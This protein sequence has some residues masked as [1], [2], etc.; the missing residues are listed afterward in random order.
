[1]SESVPNAETLR[2]LYIDEQQSL[3][4]VGRLY[5]VHPNQVRRWLLRALIP[6]RSVSEG[7]ILSGKYGV[8]SEAHREALRGGAVKARAKITSESRKK[9]SAT[10]IQRQIEPWN[11][12]IPMSDAQREKLAKTWNDPEHRRRQAE[13]QRGEKG[14]N[15]QGGKRSELDRRL[16]S[17]EWRQTRA[18]I[19]ERDNWLCQECGCKCL[20]SRD[21]K[22]HPKRK[23][24]CHHIVSRRN[25]GSDEMSNLTTLCMSCHHKLERASAQ[26][27][28]G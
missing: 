26:T 5:G 20:N 6:T 11:K 10:R 19:Y 4:G 23:I 18:K 24:Q 16:D 15:W 13:R 8:Q 27:V 2:R 14:H 21:S 25:G 22:A 1:M 12:G 3:A 9:Q 28:Q 17:W 7:T